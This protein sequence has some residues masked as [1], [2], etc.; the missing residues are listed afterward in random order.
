MS[1]YRLYYAGFDRA[2]G[3]EQIGLATSRDLKNW[4]RPSQNPV[5]PL[6]STGEADLVQTSNPCVLKIGN[7]FVMWYQGRNTVGQISICY[8]SS[9][10][11]V[12]WKFRDTPVLAVAPD[13][14]GNRVGYHHPHVI[15][16]AAK[17]VYRLWCTRYTNDTSYFLYA[18][19]P[20]GI[21]WHTVAEHVLSPQEPWE[22]RLLFYPCIVPAG[23]G[24][25]AWYSG[26]ESKK[27]WNIGRA[28]S[29]DGLHW[30]RV[31][32]RPILP[33]ALPVTLVRVW[34][35]QLARFGLYPRASLSAYGIASPNVWKEGGTY[36]MLTHDVG[37][38]G[39]LSIGYYVSPDGISWEQKG[40]DLLAEGSGHWDSFFQ[41]DPFLLVV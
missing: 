37:P 23:I 22:G 16:D 34:Y 14:Q 28:E 21:K 5:V 32:V 18:E 40:W 41:G 31:P 12:S 25:T 19:S 35:E 27:K 15:F 24:F 13:I 8:A 36:H 2:T 26:V 38:R 1:E 6:G 20:D 3:V 10:D 39:K 30:G 11:G 29:A 33:H 7:R 17:D 4:H 9:V